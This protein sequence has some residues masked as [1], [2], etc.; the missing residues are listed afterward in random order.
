M[1]AFLAR[2]ATRGKTNVELAWWHASKFPMHRFAGTLDDVI[3]TAVATGALGSGTAS[4]ALSGGVNVLILYS[5]NLGAS[6]SVII[7]KSSSSIR[8]N[9]QIRCFAI[10]TLMYAPE[11]IQR[12]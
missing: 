4:S 8:V 1:R 6:A 5:R 12:V 10:N 3:S 2:F 7:I 11:R 9:K